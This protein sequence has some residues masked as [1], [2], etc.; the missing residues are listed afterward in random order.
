MSGQGH[1]LVPVKPSASR[2]ARIVG[3][4]GWEKPDIQGET[5]SIF[6]PKIVAF[7]CEQSG[8]PAAEMAKTLKLKMPDNLE[9]VPVPCSGRIE[10]LYLLKALESGADG[11]V[12]FACYEE[13]CRYLHGNV[14]LKGRVGYAKQI[15]AK[16]GL[17]G[18]R[19]EIFHVATN[20]GVKFTEILMQKVDQLRQLGPN[21]AK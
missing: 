10:T 12:V 6:D 20:S 18:E 9:L 15:M 4:E 14:R 5:M 3:R 13:N 17:E 1:N 16:I 8:V 21:P 2:K 7:C 19:L 11:V